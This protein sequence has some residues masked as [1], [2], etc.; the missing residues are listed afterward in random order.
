MS[1]N[2]KDFREESLELKPQKRLL[3]FML[4][5][6]VPP[7]PLDEE[8]KQ[9]PEKRVNLLSRIFF[10]WL[11]PVLNT[12]Y[13]RTLKPEDMFKLTD[14]I[15]IETMYARFY[16][17]LEASLKKAKQKHIVQKCK[18]RGE[19]VETNSVDEEDDMS[20]FKLPKALT[21]IAVLK[22]FKWQY[23]KSCFY[24]ALA[25]GGMTANP[26]QTKKLISY[27]EMKSLGYETGMGKALV[28]HSVVQVLY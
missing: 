6:K 8:R 16:K 1:N 19:T 22:T 25:N 21:V 4:S 28:I 23:L 15:R 14:D 2:E 18:E 13:K 3:S 11:L 20:D 7:L 17:I 5:N 27:V 26:L 9:Y 12:G 10:L 24:L